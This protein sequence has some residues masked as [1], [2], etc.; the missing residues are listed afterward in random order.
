MATL[1][2]EPLPPD[3]AV[4]FFRSKGYRIGFAWQDVWHEE[5][6]RAFTVAKAMRPDILADIRGAVDRAI[7]QGTTLA[8]FRTELTP[9]LQ[10]K[11]WWG[12]QTM[13]DPLT[14]KAR[15][16]QLGSPRR[17]GIIFDTNVRSSYAAGRWASIQRV[18]EARPYLRY[19]AIRDGRTRPEHLAWHGTVLPVDDD[20]W[21]THYPPNGWRCRC[22][23]V[24]LSRRDL[25]RQG[26]E[27]AERPPGDAARQWRNPRT[28]ELVEVPAGIDPGFGYNPGA[29][30]WRAL[31]ARPLPDGSLSLPAISP[32]ADLPP[33]PPARPV[34]ATRLLPGGL[35]PEDYV[36]R[37]LGEFGATRA[38][39]VVFTDAIGEAVVIDDSMFIDA[40][41]RT[42]LL[43]RGRG[44]HI[45][46]IADAIRAPD[47][48]WWQWI[49]YPQGRM[50]LVRRYIARFDVAGQEAPIFAMHTIGQD[51]WSGV[52][53]FP[54]DRGDYVER[55]RRGTLAY[56]RP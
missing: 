55:Q 10:A 33:L 16:V 1:G 13:T 47:E 2:L 22:T 38:K 44:P 19:T 21:K 20:W 8:E 53:G 24:Q 40:R 5:H 28:G 39:P 51:G 30:H 35:A 54:A 3:E 15:S 23:V 42:K 43:K 48:I 6:A 50:Q 26:L 36:D 49:E 41:G 7:A 31:T 18:K 27:V 25:E 45:L 4:R 17:L 37:F 9:V 12:R 46:L 14:G 52:T 32:P 11:G 56:R 34:P 29:D